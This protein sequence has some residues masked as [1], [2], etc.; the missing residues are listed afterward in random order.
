MPVIAPLPTIPVMPWPIIA[1]NIFCHSA[2]M[3]KGSSPIR[4]EDRSTMAVC[5]TRGHPLA[6][7][8]P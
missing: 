7:P 6:S 1:R 8:T 5:T 2:S 4:S 3:L